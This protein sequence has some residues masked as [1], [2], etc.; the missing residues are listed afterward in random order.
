AVFGLPGNP[1]SVMFTALRM[2]MP[3]L[4]YLSGQN[5][6]QPV[7]LATI[8]NADARTLPLH[9]G[10]L[11]RMKSRGG[12]QSCVYVASRGSGD[13]LSMADAEGFILIPPG[14]SGAGPW[15]LLRW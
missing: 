3:V 10:R 7:P 14:E 2:V 6:S 5:E 4:R 8:E 12:T 13:V 1:V 15:P 9:W 11:V